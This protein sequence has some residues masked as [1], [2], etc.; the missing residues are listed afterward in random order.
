[1]KVKAL[2]ALMSL[3]IAAGYITVPVSAAGTTT[4]LK[5]DF[6]TV[7]PP[8]GTYSTHYYIG[9]VQNEWNDYKS[10]GGYH[11]LDDENL[12]YR[13]SI[14]DNTLDS[15]DAE[16]MITRAYGWGYAGMEFDDHNGSHPG[17]YTDMSAY[18]NTASFVF[19]INVE[20]GDLE[21]AYLA[22]AYAANEWC[23]ETADGVNFLA[24]PY[25]HTISGLN[26]ADYYD[27]EKGGYQKIVIPMKEF[28]AETTPFRDMYVKLASDN[29]EMNEIWRNTPLNPKYITGLGIVRKDSGKDK[30][31]TVDIK[32]LAIVAP[33]KPVIAEAT[34]ID[35]T[36]E[37]IWDETTDS[38]VT[39]KVIKECGG[40]REELEPTDSG[41]FVDENL[42]TAKDTKYW[43]KVTDNYYG[44]SATSDVALIEST[45]GTS[46]IKEEF[47]TVYP[48]TTHTISHY[49][50][51]QGNDWN[52]YNSGAGY[53]WLDADNTDLAYR[54]SINDNTLDSG[55][56]DGMITRE[57]GWGFVSGIFNDHEGS[58]P[59]NYVDMTKYK[60]T[61]S[62][63]FN[64]NVEKGD[65]D[66]VY[67]GVTYAASEWCLETAD[68][69]N[70]LSRPYRHTVAGVPLADYYDAEKG[71]FQTIT[72]PLSKFAAEE[73]P[74]RDMYE[75]VKINNDEAYETYKNTPLKYEYIT[76]LGI[77]RKDSGEDKEFTV[78]ISA[79][80]FVAPEKPQNLKA[81]ATGNDIEVTWEETTDNDVTYKLVKEINGVKEILTPTS[82]GR[83]V[84][85]NVTTIK[86]IK[87]TVQI[88][89][90]VYGSVSYSDSVVFEPTW[91][92]KALKEDYLTTYPVTTH[93]M[94]NF[95]IGENNGWNDYYK[96][97]YEWHWLDE[98]SIA[99]RAEMNDNT[100]ASGD[101]DGM[102]TK[103]FGWGFIGGRI[104]DH[105]GSHP[106]NYVDL[107]KYQDTAIAV[108]E[109]N[110]EDGDTDDAYLG[111][112]YAADEWCL[113][114][115]DGVNFLAN[116]YR[117][118]VSGLPLSDYY[119]AEKGG[120]QT[121]A[122]PLSEFA[123]EDMPFRD[124]YMK[125]PASSEELEETYRNTALNW[126][127]VLGLGVAR[128]D[129]GKGETF[130][131]D[132][133]NLAFV[134]PQA[135]TNLEATANEDGSVNLTWKETTDR[136]VSYKIIKQTSRKTETI[137][138]TE[139][140]K[141]TDINETSGTVSYTVVSADD[142]YGAGNPS[143]TVTVDVKIPVTAYTKVYAGTGDNKV[144]TKYLAV[145]DMT[146]AMLAGEDSKGYAACYNADGTLKSVK[147]ANLVADV[148]SSV[149]VTGVSETDTIKAFIWSDL[150]GAIIEVN[151]IA[152]KPVKVLSIGDEY[153]AQSLEKIPSFAKENG[154]D[155]EVTALYATD[156]DL[157][158]M[159]ANL[160]GYA[161]EYAISV[162]GTE[163]NG[164][165]S[166]NDVLESD[167]WD[168]VIISQ[169]LSKAGDALSYDEAGNIAEAIGLKTDAELLVQETWAYSSDYEGDDF[170][171][172][173][174]DS[175]VMWVMINEACTAIADTI[176][177]DLVM[178]GTEMFTV[179]GV[180]GA[181]L[182]DEGK[183]AAAQ[184]WYDA[185]IK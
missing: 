82:A 150:M 3:A 59:G 78:D 102:I 115:A 6:I 60:D 181:D 65:L 92:T 44:V 58:H 42:N 63:V 119:D 88:I 77:A 61:A 14:N 174:Y 159:S 112:T 137:I 10:G 104:T 111:V 48:F 31:F 140:E 33:E 24:D 178:I 142:L 8:Q 9:A 123:A 64:V 11:W 168:Y 5:E 138:P 176:G 41:I 143:N 45:T 107:T 158:M 184:V 4:A 154:K 127:Y 71:G 97:N 122:I 28:M 35:G 55:N 70:F 66:G 23:L 27:A 103:E 173:D 135:P 46:A 129:S 113:E 149:V 148:E 37:V 183:A 73:M 30:E 2:S 120:Y 93:D 131:I 98:E 16:D 57:Y 130:K 87:Y 153:S 152:K 101:A 47:I 109:I 145:G 94:I 160:L 19:D 72:I 121:I 136:D 151:E 81:V 117:Y 85:K 69:V 169:E 49:Y 163:L 26:L 29:E 126:K 54:V 13:V 75:R 167:E 133:K 91:G 86:D 40:V 76:G 132:I 22:A 155:I 134:T 79:L 36:V 84:D 125:A 17:N 99:Y 156:A 1:M 21:G 52:E 162:N 96:S 80:A 53:H 110:V 38:D 185:L 25:R 95:Y 34:V 20:K 146:V 144:E 147:V 116:P 15:G 89:D 83:Y 50:I 175:E 100:L 90:D 141:Y 56:A 74:F 139:S 12:A 108:F 170:A 164:L 177:A 32:N 157:D 67:L 106:G 124:L 180:N 171:S 68:G 182:N 165:V 105:E 128:K 114:T 7:Y 118:T 51:G 62:A 179:E 161:E 172:Y 18:E 43:V 39:Y 166:I